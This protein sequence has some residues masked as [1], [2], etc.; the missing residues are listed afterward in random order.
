MLNW[1]LMKNPINWVTISLMLILAGIV[2]HLALTATGL[3][4]ATSDTSS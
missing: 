1:N 4:P 2:G 3:T